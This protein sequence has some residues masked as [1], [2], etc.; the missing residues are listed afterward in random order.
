MRIF[1]GF[2]NQIS[3]ENTGLYIYEKSLHYFA[4]KR[5]MHK[6]LTQFYVGLD[7]KPKLQNF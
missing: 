7:L 3:K 2:S 1:K 5:K 4:K 6:T